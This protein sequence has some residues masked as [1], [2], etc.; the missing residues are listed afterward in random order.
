MASTSPLRFVLNDADLELTLTPDGSDPKLG[1]GC[2][3]GTSVLDFVRRELRLTGTKEGCKEGDC[4]ACTVLVG[5]LDDGGRV[6]YL[7]VTSCLMPL[8]EV[9]GRH[10]VTIEG[11]D[12]GQANTVQRRIV[13]AGASQCG[14]CTP[15]IVVS[16]VAQ[17]MDS[18]ELESD[19]DADCV[20]RSLSGHLCRCTGYR[21]LRDAAA[22]SF[23][24]LRGRQGVPRLVNAGELPEHFLG[25][26]ERLQALQAPP[27][28][29]NLDRPVVAG[30]TDLY[31]QQGEELPTREVTALRTLLPHRP[32][33][34][35][36]RV[37]G[38]RISIGALTSFEDLAQSEVL[39]KRIP[40]ITEFMHLVASW[41]LRNRATVGGNLINAS[42]IGDVT[43]LMLALGAEAVLEGQG[44]ARVLPLRDLYKG[45]KVLDLRPGEIL[46]GLS[47]RDVEATEFVDFEK[48]SKRRT[49]DIATVNTAARLH[50]RDGLIHQACLAAGG[51]A[52]I[53]LLLR[54]T[55]EIVRGRPIDRETLSLA[56]AEAQSEIS[57]ISDVR[58]SAGTKR[59]LVRNLLIAHF[60]KAAGMEPSDFFLPNAA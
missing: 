44:E 30:G 48:V 9:A 54:R 27:A 5:E 58:G 17:L 33:L 24:D 42:P 56:V 11:L 31:V 21:S 52:P 45:Y 47:F 1:R 40:T 38:G 55:S 10:L 14:F 4:G 12:M 32:E 25:I 50:L 2:A 41:Q 59:L 43:I 16:L 35:G 46:T 60:A 18:S 7:P 28:E 49:L 34:R 8:A 6:R 53:P 3:G 26:A 15:G 20:D 51:V 29:M 23:C 37:E 57:P 19:A 13:E 39:R 36:V 22:A